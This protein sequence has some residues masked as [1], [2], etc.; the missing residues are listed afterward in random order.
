[1]TTTGDLF[2]PQIIVRVS[3]GDRAKE[4][5][6]L[7]EFLR[8]NAE[9]MQRLQRAVQEDDREEVRQLVHRVK[10]AAQTMGAHAFVQACQALEEAA[11][12]EPKEVVEADCEEV[13]GQAA[14]LDDAIRQWMETAPG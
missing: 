7:G 1:M 2:D 3:R 4:R 9:D 13:L 8:V 10:G 6:I 14:R 11:R 12:G 5:R